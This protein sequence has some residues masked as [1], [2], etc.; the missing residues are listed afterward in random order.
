VRRLLPIL[1]NVSLLLSLLLYVVTMGMW[2]RSYWVSDTLLWWHPTRPIL[3]SA[4]CSRGRIAYQSDEPRNPQLIAR[5]YQ[6]G[7]TAYHVVP[8]PS[9]DWEAGWGVSFE[10]R[11][12]FIGFAYL[13]ATRFGQISTQMCVLPLWFVALLTALPPVAYALRARSRR[14]VMGACLRCGYDLRATPDR[15]PECGSVPTAKPARPGGSGG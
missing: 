5:L 13:R 12:T 2:L 9:D 11:H 6:P 3:Y 7:P 15:C 4:A 10:S 8:V 1:R 14:R